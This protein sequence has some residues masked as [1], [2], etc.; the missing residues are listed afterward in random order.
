MKDLFIKYGTF[1][2]IPFVVIGIVITLC[3]LRVKVKIPVTLVCLSETTGVAYIPQ[4]TDIQI[5]K[6]KHI[7]LETSQYDNIECLATEI[8]EEPNNKRIRVQ[9]NS[10]KNMH[11]N[12][13]CNAYIVTKKVLMLDLVFKKILKW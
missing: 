9:L 2:I 7:L 5:A 4:S 10:I 3:T 1:L 13:I 12:S 8:M 11:G 6:G